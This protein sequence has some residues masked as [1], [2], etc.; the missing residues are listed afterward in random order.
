MFPIPQL[1]IRQTPAL[2]AIDADPGQYSIRQPKAELQQKT[3]PSELSV[4]SY[5]PELHVNQSRAFAAYTGGGLKELTDR[6]IAGYQQNFMQSL[7]ARADLGS[8]LAAINEKG[9]NPIAD[10]YAA[11]THG[12]PIPEY[13]GTASM[14]NVDIRFDVRPPTIRF[15]PAK[16]DVEVKANKPEIEY[17]RGKLD[18]YVKQYNKVEYI[19]PALDTKG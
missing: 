18:I 14:D 16:V 7:A 4:E 13:R 10:V 2:L 19:P 6:L 11:D 1:Q 9:S 12:N 15:T 3:T 17:T 5:K 8:R